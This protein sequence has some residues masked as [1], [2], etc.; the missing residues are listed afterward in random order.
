MEVEVIAAV[1]QQAQIA[2]EEPSADLETEVSLLIF[3]QCG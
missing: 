1:A 3:M 2:E